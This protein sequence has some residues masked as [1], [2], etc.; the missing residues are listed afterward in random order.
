MGCSIGS[1]HLDPAD[2]ELE[3]E[4]SLG[5]ISDRSIEFENLLQILF[6][7]KNIE[8]HLT[9][10]DNI[11]YILSRSKHHLHLFETYPYAYKSLIEISLKYN[12]NLS[13]TTKLFEI[14]V[15]ISPSVKSKAKLHIL[16]VCN[17]VI[18]SIKKFI[19]TDQVVEL[20]LSL[21]HISEPT[22]PY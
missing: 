4:I 5:R 19:Q 3:K 17:I 7:V 2:I 9:A 12:Y 18:F 15:L 10:L 20:G 8:S 6:Q 11:L 13:V 14:F 21:I 22:R 1:K 16:N